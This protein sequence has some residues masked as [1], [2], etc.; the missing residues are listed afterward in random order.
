MWGLP[1]S[2][3]KQEYLRVDET[4]LGRVILRKN[5][6]CDK[7]VGYGTTGLADMGM[8]YQDACLS[9]SCSTSHLDSAD[10]P[11]EEAEDG[12]ANHTADAKDL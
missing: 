3:Q 9:S 1:H 12:L 7:G 5:R 4:G 11:G 8:P 10:V 2:R 6:S